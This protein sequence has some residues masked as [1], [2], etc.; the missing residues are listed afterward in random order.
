MKGIYKFI[1][2]L[3]LM[4]VA[5]MGISY[6][7]LH[8]NSEIS[9]SNIQNVHT[10]SYNIKYKSFKSYSEFI[11]FINT[12]ENE[13]MKYLKSLVEYRG[14]VTVIPTYTPTPIPLPSPIPLVKSSESIGY[15]YSKTNVQVEGVDE[16]DI[17]KTDGRY[18]YYI[19][20]SKLYIIKAYPINESKLVCSVNI[21]N[22][23]ARSL[24]Y[25][26]PYIIVFAPT[27]VRYHPI[28]GLTPI[29]ITPG[30]HMNTTILVFKF[31]GTNVK[32]IHKY[33]FSGFY[34]GSRLIKD[35][36]YVIMQSPIT[37]A[38]NTIPLPSYSIDGITHV[39][40]VKKI[41]YSSKLPYPYMLT[42]VFY[43][44]ISNWKHNYTSFLNPSASV[45]YVSK[46]NIYIAS[47]IYSVRVMQV[48]KDNTLGIKSIYGYT[49]ITRI[50]LKNG[51]KVVASGIVR[52][53][54][55][56]QFS[57]DEYRDYFRIATTTYTSGRWLNNLY[58]FNLNF[59]LVGKIEN[60]S[61]GERI[62]AVRFMGDI[63]F[64]VTFK[65]TDPLFV[66]N[67]KNPRKPK[68]VGEL[69]ISG[70]SSYLHPIGKDLLIGIGKE[71]KPSKSG[72]FA[73]YQGVKVSLFDISNISNP[74]ELSRLVFGDRGSS[75]PVLY[76]HRAF[77]YYPEE[78]LILFPILIAKV[79]EGS[80][81][82]VSGKPIW[83]GLIILKMIGRSLI[84]YGNISNFKLG[85]LGETSLFIRRGIYIKKYIY[86]LSAENILIYDINNHTIIK[87]IT[88]YK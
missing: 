6:Y 80:P 60:F 81:P 35:T 53:Y 88:L 34:I 31:N 66:I 14:T 69:K 87:Q 22:K 58:I 40:N 65:K 44:N 18:I 77:Q 63:A 28:P 72:K 82:Y 49:I 67:L 68:I 26:K 52:G 45:I 64:I 4:E 25:I 71:A 86:A 56:N 3:I 84:V 5:F 32:C 59:K 7:I 24:F 11:A 10:G 23:N 46:S 38:N 12:R 85:Y 47:K 54:P 9:I 78:K 21:K 19:A 73:W 48:S 61:I 16:P 51:V 79:P 17:V 75:T 29:P 37:K 50:S 20:D 55:L 41:Y 27:I 74:V 13:Y 39:L 8:V 36:L 70:Y 2:L 1:L 76:N 62:Y 42:T 30:K 83:Q 33:S 57:M 43:I 15:P